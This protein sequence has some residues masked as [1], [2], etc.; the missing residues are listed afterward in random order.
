MSS[1]PKVYIA[2]PECFMPNSQQLARDAVA[3]CDRM[4]FEGW[5]PVL[6]VEGAPAVCG[7]TPQQRAASICKKNMWLIENCDLI[8]A[9]CNNWRG[10]EPDG[11]TCFELGYGYMLGK[12]LYCFL[13]DIRPCVDK[14]KGK[15]IMC[16][17]GVYRDE[18]N[19]FFESGPLNLMLSAPATVVGGA[20]ED[21]LKV[22]AKDFS[23][24][25]K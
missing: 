17:D 2:G 4:G 22:A 7:D 16:D 9:N 12:K 3:L 23:T 19:R 20:L 8:I 25:V 1:R 15:K 14:Y 5:S 6:P 10:E 13:D 18:Q 24:E 11:G 21:A